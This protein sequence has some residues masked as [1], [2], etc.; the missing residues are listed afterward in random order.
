V[1]ITCN[2]YRK[3]HEN[4]DGSFPNR[5]LLTLGAEQHAVTLAAG[6]ATQGLVPANIYFFYSA[7]DQVIHDV[8]LQNYLLFFASTVR[9]V[10]QD[11][12]HIMVI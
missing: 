1:G 9:L 10:G 12:R 5:A 11:G 3:F 2:A 8:A 4:N 7:Y 6:M